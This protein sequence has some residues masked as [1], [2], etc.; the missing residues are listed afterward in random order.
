MY[1]GGS[2]EMLFK[3]PLRTRFWTSCVIFL[4]K[5]FSQA[6]KSKISVGTKMY[7]C[8]WKCTQNFK[9]KVKFIYKAHLQQLMLDKVLC[10]LKGN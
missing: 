2:E 7:S 8:A 10:K 6:D 1:I 4:K 3:F 9:V 5:Y